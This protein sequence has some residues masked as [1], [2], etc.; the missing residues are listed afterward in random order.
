MLGEYPDAVQ[1]NPIVMI[2]PYMQSQY[3]EVE[4]KLALPQEQ[5]TQRSLTRS[6]TLTRPKSLNRPSRPSNVATPRRNI[7]EEDIND[8]MTAWRFYYLA[9]TCCFPNYILSKWGGMDSNEM[10]RAWREKVALCSIV[11]YMCAGLA[12]ITFGLQSAICQVEQFSFT[13]QQVGG[14][15]AGNNPHHFVI[16]G[17][18][19]NMDSVLKTHRGINVNRAAYFRNGSS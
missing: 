5:G 6:R 4:Q 9:I 15:G 2:P 10:Q 12:F 3:Q 18:V 14:F 8:R 11:L 7:L 19:Y 1:S 17:S 16:F 13:R